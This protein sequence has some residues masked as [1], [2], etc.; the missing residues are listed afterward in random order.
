MK[1]PLQKSVRPLPQHEEFHIPERN[2]IP[3]MQSI[4]LNWRTSACGFALVLMAGADILHALCAG[5]TSKLWF[6]FSFISAGL[7]GI[8]TQDAAVSDE[9]IAKLRVRVKCEPPSWGEFLIL[10]FAQ[11]RDSEGMIGDLAELFY[12]D[13]ASGISLRR[14]RIRYWG[15]VLKSIGPQM[16]TKAKNIGLIGLIP[17]V[18]N[19]AFKRG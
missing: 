5:N 19:H 13:L 9:D 18:F 15:R 10:V 6:D 12:R 11:K 7:G 16:W 1:K 2:R 14:V 3:I 8:M 17:N 4:V